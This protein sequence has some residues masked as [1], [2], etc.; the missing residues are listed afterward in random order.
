M[1]I[2]ALLY[3]PAQLFYPYNWTCVLSSSSFAPSEAIRATESLPTHV[4]RQSLSFWGFVTA[5]M[6]KSIQVN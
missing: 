1:V 6:P 5:S 4:A 3:L 2:K